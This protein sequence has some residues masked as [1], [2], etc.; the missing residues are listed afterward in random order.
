MI[1]ITGIIFIS[2]WS[3]LWG[4]QDIKMEAQAQSEAKALS[5]LDARL[6]EEFSR[7]ISE[8]KV[9]LFANY[10]LIWQKSGQDIS[11]SHLFHCRAGGEYVKGL[12]ASGAGKR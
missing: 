9:M 3:L 1:I 11:Y 8:H 5:K 6:I 10:G 12:S 2:E 4:F 7:Q